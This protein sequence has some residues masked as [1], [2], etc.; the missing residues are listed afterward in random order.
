MKET[1]L[2]KLY[3]EK[4]DTFTELPEPH[5]WQRIEA[6][7]DKKQKKRIVPIWWYYGGAAA[8]LLLGLW[9]LNPF[10][11]NVT[12]PIVTST[13]VDQADKEP[14]VTK[15]NK[16]PVAKKEQSFS[17]KALNPVLQNPQLGKN[18]AAQKKVQ[19]TAKKSNNYL[20][21]AKDKATS[22]HK[23]EGYAL[24]TPLPQNEAPLAQ[25]NSNKGKGKLATNTNTKDSVQNPKVA[26][27]KAVEKPSIYTAI[28]QQENT[29][30]QAETITNKWSFGAAVAPVYFNGLG[31]DSPIHSIFSQNNKSGNVNL[32]YG[33]QVAYNVTKKIKVRS[34]IHRVNF[35]Y[36]TEQI[37]FTAA[38][39]N[40]SNNAL[41]DNIN[42]NQSA[43]SIVVA[44][45]P[46]TQSADA[47]LSN[48]DLVADSPGFDGNMVQQMGYVEI[49]L[50]VSYSLLQK[51]FGLQLIGGFSSLLLVDNAITLETQDLVTEVGQ[52]NNLNNTNFST[53]IGLGINYKFTKKLQLNVEP[54]FKYQLST[55]S[56]A[57]GNFNPYTIGVYSGLNF[58]F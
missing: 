1:N 56:S 2:D 36:D 38:G 25:S 4:F 12:N 16:V 52:A 11:T 41:I 21:Q 7:L 3:Q 10:K 55:F 32:S 47:A 50:E 27:D 17:K 39:I 34:G 48:T 24:K 29:V 35:G 15:N 40:S 20:V 8:V 23:Q 9:V 45:S 51:K 6:S 54:M 19:P 13:V 14:A 30:K 31:S 5:V 46:K 44:N 22:K 37:S 43:R 42:Y 58:K 49:P 33:L 18:V 28:A 57:D 26:L 53:N